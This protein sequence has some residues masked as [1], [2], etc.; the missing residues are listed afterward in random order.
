MPLF[1]GLCVAL[2]AILLFLSYL[3]RNGPSDAWPPGW[4]Q[5]IAGL[6]ILFVGLVGEACVWLW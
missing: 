2:G 6:V 3:Q 4:D 5:P 1:F